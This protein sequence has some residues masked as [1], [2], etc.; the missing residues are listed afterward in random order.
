MRVERA[1]PLMRP[2]RPVKEGYGSLYYSDR[3]V[4]VNGCHLDQ[5]SA[6]LHCILKLS[7]HDQWFSVNAKDIGVA[8]IYCD[9]S[10]GE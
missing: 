6:A 10:L 5:N 8:A 3:V 4:E 7:T 1:P 9:L 2:C